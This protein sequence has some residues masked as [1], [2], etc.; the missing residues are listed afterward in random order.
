MFYSKCLDPIDYELFSEHILIDK[1]MEKGSNF[2]YEHHHRKWEYGLAIKVLLEANVKTVLNVGGGQSPLS[3]ALKNLGMAVTEIDPME[4]TQKIDGIKYIV[5][6]FPIE[7]LPK[8]D[9]IVCTSVIEH[10]PND[11]LF[12]KELLMHSNKIVFLTTDFSESGDAHS[13]AHLRTY[14]EKELKELIEIAKEY[15]FDTIGEFDYS[16]T[17][18]HVYDYNFASLALRNT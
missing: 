5:D 13:T 6:L 15:K 9:A 10:V 7:N 8:Y 14:S 2:R 4:P 17:G 16:P 11:V 12:F 1:I 18:F 3:V